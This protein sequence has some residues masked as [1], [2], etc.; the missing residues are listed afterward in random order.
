MVIML[1]AF[2]ALRQLYL[3]TVTHYVANTPLLVGLGYPVG[4]TMCFILEVSY[5]LIRRR[6]WQKDDIVAA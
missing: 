4:W 1:I 5:W 6:K 2:V 3:F